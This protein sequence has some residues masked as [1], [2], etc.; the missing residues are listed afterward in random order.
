MEF[1]DN[2]KKCCIKKNC[3]SSI[4]DGISIYV[5]KNT[6]WGFVGLDIKYLGLDMC[7]DNQLMEII[8][9]LNKIKKKYR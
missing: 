5:I 9:I 7:G 2:I 8:G 3:P 4:R 1:L 6:E